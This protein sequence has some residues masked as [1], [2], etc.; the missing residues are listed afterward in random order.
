MGDLT[1]NFLNLRQ[2]HEEMQRE[3]EKLIMQLRKRN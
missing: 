2:N 1:E 3:A